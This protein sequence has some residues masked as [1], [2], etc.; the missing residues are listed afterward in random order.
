[1]HKIQSNPFKLIKTRKPQKTTLVLRL[2]LGVEA[3]AKESAQCQVWSFKARA[4][5]LLL[6]QRDTLIA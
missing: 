1:M 5:A 2:M 6:V 3:Q 4:L